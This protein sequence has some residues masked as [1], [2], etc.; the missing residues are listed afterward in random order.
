MKSKKA[1]APLLLILLIGVIIYF[2]FVST[3]SIAF[4]GGGSI[5]CSET[6]TQTSLSCEINKKMYGSYDYR[7]EANITY[8]IQNQGA[9]AKYSS[10]K[11]IDVGNKQIAVVDG[12]FSPSVGDSGLKVVPWKSYGLCDLIS[13]QCEIKNPVPPSHGVYEISTGSF[14]IYLSNLNSTEQQACDKS[15]LCVASQII[16]PQPT[17]DTLPVIENPIT[18]IEG[19]NNNPVDSTPPSIPVSNNEN[20]IITFIKNFIDKILSIFER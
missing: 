4:L 11:S 19:N 17:K 12:Y 10:I 7:P 14:L 8:Q 13:G 15:G 2:G 20:S 5:W 3:G 16:T 6:S 9:L 1:V 18:P